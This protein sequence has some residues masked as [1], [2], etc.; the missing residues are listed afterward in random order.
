MQRKKLIAVFLIGSLIAFPI[1]IVVGYTIGF[2]V[3]VK[4]VAMLAQEFVDID[5]DLI[6]K[7]IIRYQNSAMT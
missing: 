4:A 5:Y 1:G 2:G 3:A 6:S 7:Y